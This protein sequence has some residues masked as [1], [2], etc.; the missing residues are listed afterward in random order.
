MD[1]IWGLQEFKA[2][3]YVCDKYLL[4]GSNFYKWGGDKFTLDG[5][6]CLEIIY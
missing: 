6:K 4:E 1:Y 5:E 2:Y 3:Q